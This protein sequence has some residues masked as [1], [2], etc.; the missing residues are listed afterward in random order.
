MNRLSHYFA[1]RHL[2]VTISREGRYMMGVE[3]VAGMGQAV[4][5]M[6]MSIPIQ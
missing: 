5:Y 1:F 6:R 3:F 4:Q 2:V